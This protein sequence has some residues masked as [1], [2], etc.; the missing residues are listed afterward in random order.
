ME[1]VICNV[2]KVEQN[3]KNI[4]GPFFCTSTHVDSVCVWGGQTILATC[5]ENFTQMHDFVAM[6]TKMFIYMFYLNICT[7]FYIFL[8]I[9]CAGKLVLTAKIFT[10]CTITSVLCIINSVML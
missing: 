3:F 6:V 4:K 1:I 9:C 7:S 8:V 10:L 2:L 5:R